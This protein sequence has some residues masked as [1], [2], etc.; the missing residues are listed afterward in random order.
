[1]AAE[2]VESGEPSAEESATEHPADACELSGA[3]YRAGC[4][5]DR[6][7]PGIIGE[8]R[9]RLYFFTWYF[10]RALFYVLFGLRL[11]GRE[12]VPRSGGF[13]I[14]CNHQSF[15][16]PV[17]A[18]LVA[19]PRRQIHYMAR[20]TLFFPPFSWLI[21]TYNAF[22]IERSRGDFSAL[23]NAA[24]RLRAGL[25]V[26]VFPEGT[27]TPDGKLQ[28][29]RSGAAR[30]SLAAGVPILPCY[31]HGAYR[32]WPRTRMFFRPIRGMEVSVGEPLQPEGKS[33]S[34]S[35]REKLTARL[36]NA[37]AAMEADAYSS[38]ESSSGGIRAE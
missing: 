22:P 30:L 33:A 26:L 16:D 17:I 1:M 3:A 20:R 29:V 18:G 23:E 7:C 5:L 9:Y 25:P 15:M 27:R 21:R 28:K 14:A 2:S 38:S 12:S 34:R 35:D 37:L 31:I 6:P 19:G 11:R 13:I 4:R 8:L 36:Q 10:C 24:A 32:A